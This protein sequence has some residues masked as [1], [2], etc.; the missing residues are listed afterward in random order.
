MQMGA[1][2]RT[3]RHVTFLRRTFPCLERVYLFINSRISS[4][5][6]LV[7]YV[8]RCR[9]HRKTHLRTSPRRITRGI[10]ART[11]FLRRKIW[12]NIEPCRCLC[13]IAQSL[14]NVNHNKNPGHQEFVING[15][16]CKSFSISSLW[17]AL[18]I[19]CR[20]NPCLW[21]VS[22]FIPWKCKG[23]TMEEIGLCICIQC[24]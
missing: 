2:F 24:I 7:F 5:T 21:T 13:D 19:S 18:E 8:A 4:G 12:V 20:I 11:I 16:A 9:I 14:W 6:R 17:I 22:T 23:I 10:F 1:I 3:A 15:H